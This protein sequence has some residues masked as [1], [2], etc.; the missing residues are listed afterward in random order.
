MKSSAGT[1]TCGRESSD[2]AVSLNVPAAGGLHPSIHPPGCHAKV[3]SASLVL[4][5]G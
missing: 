5:L 1:E 3:H 4:L 2:S